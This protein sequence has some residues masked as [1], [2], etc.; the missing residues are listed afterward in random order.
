MTTEALRRSASDEKPLK[1][2]GGEAT[3]EGKTGVFA[4]SILWFF[5]GAFGITIGEPF[6]P[7]SMLRVGHNQ[8]DPGPFPFPLRPTCTEGP[9]TAAPAGRGTN[10]LG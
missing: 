5:A 3:Q 6:A 8:N 4:S 1:P 7:Q 10:G 9:G 2:E